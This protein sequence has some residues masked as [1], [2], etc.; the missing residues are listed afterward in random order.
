MELHLPDGW[1]REHKR[2]ARLDP[3]SP[4]VQENI[5]EA[6]HALGRNDEAIAAY[7]GALALD[8]N[9]V[10]TLAQLC[11]ALADKGAVDEAKQIL[12]SRLVAVDGEG[13][14]TTRCRLELARTGPDAKK[15]FTGIGSRGSKRSQGPWNQRKPCWAC[16][17]LFR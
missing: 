10:F 8:P 5:G 14:Y 9:L 13:N 1:L 11:V 15:C 4:L 16:L 12:T 6:L 2:A 17:R 7:R 3:L